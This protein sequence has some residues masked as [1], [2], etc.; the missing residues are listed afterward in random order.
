[1]AASRSSRRRSESDIVA[2]YL[3]RIT[4]RGLPEDMFD[5]VPV[6]PPTN[7]ELARKIERAL[8]QPLDFDVHVSSERTDV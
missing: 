6:D 1:M 2:S 7:E 3:V 8:Q 4:L 5:H